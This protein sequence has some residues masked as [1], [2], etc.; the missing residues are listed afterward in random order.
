M[1]ERLGRYMTAPELRSAFLEFFADRG[2][3]VV[4]SSPLIPLGDPTLLFT[5][6]GM[7]QFK[8][9]FLGNE[10]RSYLRATT[11]QKCV[12]AGGKHNDLDNVGFT[13]RHHTFFE[14]L[15]NF[16]FGDYFK[17]QAIA[18]A[19][20]FLTGV[21]ELPKE[22]LWVTIYKEDDEAADLW[23]RIAGIPASRIVRLGEKENFWAMGETGPCGPCSEIVVDRG[24]GYACGPDC[25]LGVCDCDRWLEVWNL[26]FMQFMRDEAG[27]MSPLPRPS[28]DTGLGLE[29]VASVLQ[30]A[31]TNYD[32]DLF[33][34]IISKVEGI[35]G[36]KAGD[37]APV[38]PFHVIA[39]HIRSCVFL[40]ADGVQPSNEGR[41]Y[42]MRRILRR[43]VRFGRV[44][45]I[46]RPF[47]SELV[48][49]VCGLMKDAYPEVEDKREYIE[50]LLTQEEIRFLNTLEEGQTRAGGLIAAVKSAGLSAVPGKDAFLLYD[51]FGFPIDLTKDIAREQGL[52]VDEKGFEEAMAEQRKRSRTGSLGLQTDIAAM[53]DLVSDLPPTRFTGYEGLAEAARVLALLKGGSKSTEVETGDEAAVVLDVTPFYAT[54][55][56]EESDT[57]ALELF[58]PGQVEGRPAAQVLGVSRTASGVYLHRVKATGEGIMVGQ[59]VLARVNP[60]RRKGL[61]QHHTATHLIHRA[62]RTV[63]GEHAQ[64]SGSLVQES[65]LRF[66]FSHFQ[67]LS[68]EELARVEDVVNE[69]VMADAAVVWREMP[70]EEAR[71]A[72]AVALF[73]EKYAETVRVVDICGYSRELCGGTHVRRTGE[74]G[75]VQIVAESAVA[76]GVRRLE[77]VAGKAA[78]SRAR[79]NA[80]TLAELAGRLGVGVE[81]VPAR[82]GGLVET[83]SSLEREAAQAKR[84]KLDDVAKGLLV[85]AAR[86][87]RAGNRQV[88]V[89]RQDTMDVDDLRDLGDRLRAGGASVAVLGS[90]REG[91][92]TMVAMVEP[93]AAAA[94]VDAVAIVKKGAALMGGSGGGKRHLAQAGGRK[95]EELDRAL[96]ASAEEAGDLLCKVYGS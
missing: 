73:G 45:G 76:A 57:G 50:R 75:Q 19:R 72:G 2:H 37:G 44:L 63:L 40:A 83:V 64:Q 21:L 48:P 67:A 35:S 18:Y 58:A 88:V 12:R 9:V 38:F 5:N 14:M 36:K 15:G 61:Q 95:P 46:E 94:G 16:S 1:G 56:G 84:S 10:K 89:S 51:T 22:R 87:S 96:A 65:R 80:A 49:V 24:E 31:D 86:L 11:S 20:E 68:R 70:I 92:C 60:E 25:K 82:V 33:A 90:A 52:S 23:R 91:R 6:A 54:G 81:D 13:A 3:T 55:G 8:D 27:R 26:V 62:L 71:K 4:P 39:D 79:E 43:A 53:Q 30:G 42:V 47:M 93:D 74:I 78:L 66:D 77:G 29:R 17:E 34:P 32:T 41:G 69:M 7:V 85:K 28:I 59:T